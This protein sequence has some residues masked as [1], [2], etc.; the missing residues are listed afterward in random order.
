M[1][2]TVETIAETKYLR[3]VQ[4]GKWSYITRANAN[5]V[6]C[7]VPLTDDDKVLLIEQY[8]PPVGC[9]VI[10]LPAGLSGDLPN[11]A[12]EALEESA[13]RELLEETGYQAKHMRRKA[14]VASSAGL[15]DEVVTLFVAAGLEKIAAGGGD[16]SENITVHEVPLAEVDD[17][18]ARAQIDGKL[19]DSRV[20]AGLHFLRQDISDGE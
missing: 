5:G 7:I 20:Y 8:R 13:R 17:W 16:E 6:V 18:L 1:D 11:Q 4:R 14:V 9:H 19:I 15:T 12:D 2:E 10:E 3:L